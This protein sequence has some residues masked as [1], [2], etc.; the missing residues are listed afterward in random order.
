MVSTP[1]CKFSEGEVLAVYLS[2]EM[3]SAF[4]DMPLKTKAQSAFRKVIE[5]TGDDLSFDAAMVEDAFSIT[6]SGHPA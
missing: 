6:P 4:H 5:Q 1:F 2:H 3:M